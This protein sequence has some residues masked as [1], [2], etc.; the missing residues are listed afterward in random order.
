VDNGSEKQKYLRLTEYLS[1]FD[2]VKLHRI[3]KNL[4]PGPAI[5]IGLSEISKNHKYVLMSHNDTIM[6]EGALAK[7]LTG[8]ENNQRYAAIGAIQFSFS[9]PRQIRY[10]GGRFRNPGFIP[11]HYRKL[12]ANKAIQ[13]VDWLDFTTLI[14]NVQHLK[15]IGF[16]N[17]I[18]DFYW[19]DSEWSIR[20]KKRG[21]KLGVCTDAGVLHKFGATL[22][23]SSNF[24]FFDKMIRHHL[25]VINMHGNKIDIAMAKLYWNYKAIQF[26]LRMQ[27]KKAIWIWSTLRDIGKNCG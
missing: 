26:I 18:F 7:L 24:R 3:S 2:S 10:S 19:E 25:L 6:L 20:A 9:Q 8:I 14:F 27:A 15:D 11:S 12:T 13:E 22:G 4:G 16:P 23:T 5:S 1:T 21:L 17:K